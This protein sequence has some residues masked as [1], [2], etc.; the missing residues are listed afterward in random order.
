MAARV[1]T[2][3]QRFAREKT[4][5]SSSFYVDTHHEPFPKFAILIL[6]LRTP[7][8]KDP[9]IITYVIRALTRSFLHLVLARLTF[10]PSKKFH[11]AKTRHAALETLLPNSW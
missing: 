6:I 3:C 10:A 4:C 8:R 2:L 9:L 5:A 11:L 1:D 7:T